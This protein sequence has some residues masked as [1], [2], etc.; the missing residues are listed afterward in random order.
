LLVT[1]LLPIE[2]RVAVDAVGVALPHRD[3]FDRVIVAT[4]RVHGLILVTK[5]EKIVN[6][7]VVST[8][9]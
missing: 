3:P 9:W 4:A 5:D 8:M 1:S 6:A 2:A 7:N